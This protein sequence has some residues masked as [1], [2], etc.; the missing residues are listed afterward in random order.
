M[1]PASSLRLVLV[2]CLS[3]GCLIGARAAG[4]FREIFDGTS[5]KG[6]QGD[7]RLWSVQNGT[8]VGQTSDDDPIDKNSFLV[9]RQGEV[10][11]FE[12]KFDYKITG[13]NSGVQYRAFQKPK[14]WGPFVMGGPQADFEAG[15][16]H[17]G[18]LYGERSRGILAKRGEKVLVGP[19]HKPTVVGSVGDAVE[20]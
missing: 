7:S 13:G 2:V 3:V 11:D 1:S 18:G 19:D 4:Q 12:L 17:S 10:D 15:K 5:L 8:I 20:L 14:E 9:W 6:W 16:R